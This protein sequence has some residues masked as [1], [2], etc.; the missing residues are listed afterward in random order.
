MKTAPQAQRF[1]AAKRKELARRH[2]A[3]KVR[4]DDFTMAAANQIK[5]Q[6]LDVSGVEILDHEIGPDN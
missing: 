2:A 5:R 3:G 4:L 1:K 6:P